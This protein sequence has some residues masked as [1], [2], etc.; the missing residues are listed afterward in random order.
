MCLQKYKNIPKQ[1]CVS[2]Y[3]FGQLL[4]SVACLY[5]DGGITR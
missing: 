2:E 5:A 3:F 4:K 1:T